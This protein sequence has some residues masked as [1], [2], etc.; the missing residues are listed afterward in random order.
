MGRP[1]STWRH[2]PPETWYKSALWLS[3]RAGQLRLEPLCRSCL[4]RGVVTPAEIADHVIP[5]E[6][7]WSSFALGRLQSLCGRCHSGPK[8]AV[9][10]RGYDKAVGDDGWPLDPRH[11]ANRGWETVKVRKQP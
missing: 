4:E 6:G 5:H 10:V 1:R 9:E 3:R 11:P 2:K 7:D 8:Q